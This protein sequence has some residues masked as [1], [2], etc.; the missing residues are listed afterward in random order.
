MTNIHMAE[1]Y[2]YMGEEKRN[3]PYIRQGMDYAA[4]A[5]DLYLNYG[6]IAHVYALMGDRH[7]SIGYAYKI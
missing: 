1:L 3:R 6:N 7:S 4:A 5:L 2:Q